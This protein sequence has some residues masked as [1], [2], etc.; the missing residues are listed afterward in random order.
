MLLL[1]CLVDQSKQVIEIL[2]RFDHQMEMNRSGSS[3]TLSITHTIRNNV[4]EAKLMLQFIVNGQPDF[5]GG[6]SAAAPII[7]SII[8]LIKEQRLAANKITVG[9]INPTIYQNPDAFTDVCAF[10][11]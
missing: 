7:T 11:P 8:T 6:K 10:L 4:E 2:L 3:P 9:F 5:A 1:N